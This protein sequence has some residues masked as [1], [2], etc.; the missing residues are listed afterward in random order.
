VKTIDAMGQVLKNARRASIRLEA[1][2]RSL[3]PWTAT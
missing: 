1:A 2:Q 3:K